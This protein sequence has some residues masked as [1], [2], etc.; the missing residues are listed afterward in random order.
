MFCID[1]CI[2]LCYNI[3]I[4]RKDSV[5]RNVNYCNLTEEQKVLARKLR[6]SDYVNRIYEVAESGNII[7]TRK[8]K[9]YFLAI[10]VNKSENLL[11]TIPHFRNSNGY[12]SYL[13][14]RQ[15]AIMAK[16][17]C[18]RLYKSL[19]RQRNYPYLEMKNCKGYRECIKHKTII[20]CLILY[21]KQ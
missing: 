7:A 1:I 4:E 16:E 20:Y 17:K 9:Y 6:P 15:L 10:R 13:V 3:G 19:K 18:I 11:I 21:R 5:M 2:T 14:H 8:K 12:S